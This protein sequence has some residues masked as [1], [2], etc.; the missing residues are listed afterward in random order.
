MGVVHAKEPP[1]MRKLGQEEWKPLDEVPARVDK[2]RF[3]GIGKT[4]NDVLKYVI[5]DLLHAKNME[6]VVLKAHGA[7]Q[8][9][10]SLEAFDRIDIILDTSR[11]KDASPDGFEV[12]FD[13]KEKRS[14]RGG[15]DVVF[16]TGSNEPNL[17]FKILSPNMLG[18]G[19]SLSAQFN[20]G[21]K[22][23]GFNIENTKPFLH[24]AKPKLKQS[25]FG[26]TYDNIWSAY[27]E[28]IKGIGFE[29]LFES[30][31]QVVHTLRWEGVW[32]DL[33]CLSPS[34]PFLIRED[35]GHSVKS[36][37][38]HILSFDQR[39]DALLP[40]RG[41][42]F[43]LFQEYAGLGGSVNFVKNEIHYQ[44][45]KCI[46]GDL[47]LQL[48]FMAGLV[49]SIG[50]DSSVKINDRFFL[51]GPLSVRGFAQNGV[52]PQTQDFSLGAEAYWAAGLHA[53]TPLPFRPLPEFFNKFC[54]SH[55]FLNTGNI[56]NFAF[57]DD[58]H[59]NTM[60]LLSGLRW[61][62]G[63]GLAVSLAGIAKLEINYT[64]PLSSQH[65]DRLNG[66][67]QFGIGFNFL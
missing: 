35:T 42:Y 51:G 2:V 1:Q 15:G 48:S 39:D 18:R 21:K 13:L 50:A 17:M 56:G 37:L 62:C 29:C 46:L 57:T 38:K 3:E 34:T 40:S 5:G 11:G 20:Y 44:V 53:Y 32:R 16:E 59:H 65:G 27:Q 54:R 52:G 6:E 61:S 66:G 19:E 22:N 25:V 30:Y 31:P 12:T 10:E 8:Q 9:L 33:K 36:S 28:K 63:M 41:S 58:Y 43:H 47:V 4:K 60:V 67:L 55:F 45:N 49:K 26:S 14:F 64:V 23:L 24:W 7:R